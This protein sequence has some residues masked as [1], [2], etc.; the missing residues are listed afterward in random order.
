M[1]S[2]ATLGADFTENQCLA[3]WIGRASHCSVTCQ[4]G[5]PEELSCHQPRFLLPSSAPNTAPGP[6]PAANQRLLQRRLHTSPAGL[7]N[8]PGSHESG[9]SPAAF[10]FRP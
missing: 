4:L 9:W 7:G 8:P 1:I 6:A 5:R 2:G 10:P 3:S